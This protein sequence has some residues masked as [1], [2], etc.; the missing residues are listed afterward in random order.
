M[1]PILIF[2][3]SLIDFWYYLMILVKFYFVYKHQR[4]IPA[5]CYAARP[6]PDAPQPH[7]ILQHHLQ[8]RAVA[9][10]PSQAGLLTSYCA[11][12]PLHMR[13]IDLLTNTQ[14]LNTLFDLFLFAEQRLGRYLQ[15]I[16]SVVSN[17]LYNAYLQIRWWF[18]SRILYSASAV[19]AA[20]MLDLSKYR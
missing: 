9:G 12:E 16:A 4:L 7:G 8:V 10:T 2:F 14:P 6:S 20:A 15:Q 11:V 19:F 1:L 3:I 13:C 17:L 5:R 18:Q